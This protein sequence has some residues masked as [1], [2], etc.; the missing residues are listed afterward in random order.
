MGGLRGWRKRRRK[1]EEEEGRGEDK[2]RTRKGRG[3]GRG[4]GYERRKGWRWITRRKG[5]GER[6]KKGRKTQQ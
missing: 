4:E 5:I 2:G 3:R 1:R 6:E